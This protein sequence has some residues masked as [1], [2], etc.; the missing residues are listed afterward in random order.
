MDEWTDIR[1][2]GIPQEIPCEVKQENG[3]IKY[4]CGHSSQYASGIIELKRD[5]DMFKWD[6]QTYLIKVTH[7]K[8]AS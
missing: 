5:G 6:G 2:R 3:N 1:K 4:G 7:W 8:Y